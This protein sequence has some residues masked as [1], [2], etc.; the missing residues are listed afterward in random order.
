MQVQILP[1]SFSQS[2]RLNRFCS[3]KSIVR[4]K[5]RMA[6]KTPNMS[7]YS[8][9]TNGCPTVD[10]ITTALLISKNNYHQRSGSELMLDGYNPSVKQ[11]TEIKNMDHGELVEEAKQAINKVFGDQSVSRSKTKE[12]LEE[13]ASEIEVILDTMLDA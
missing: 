11:Q 4:Q 5:W 2:I 7:E 1:R 3:L 9:Q 12:S 6:F 8:A 13:L 10:D